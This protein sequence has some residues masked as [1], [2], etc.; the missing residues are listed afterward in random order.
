[1]TIPVF[2]KDASITGLG[3]TKVPRE[4]LSGSA[5]TIILAGDER[6]AGRIAWSRNGA[7]GVALDQPLPVD[8]E[9]FA[10]VAG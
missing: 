9:L 1:M 3:L 10:D 8:H 4:T 2:I 6:I 5:V 7:A